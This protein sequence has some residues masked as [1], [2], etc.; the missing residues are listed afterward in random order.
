MPGK[1]FLHSILSGD[2][3]SSLLSNFLRDLPFLVGRTKISVI[4]WMSKQMML[5]TKENVTLFIN[6]AS[7]ERKQKLFYIL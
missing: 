7:T 2:V 3:P 4:M 1:F 5:T 6:V